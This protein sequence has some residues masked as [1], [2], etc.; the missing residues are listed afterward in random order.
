MFSENFVEL[1]GIL[2]ANDYLL[3]V[4]MGQTKTSNSLEGSRSDH[5]YVQ[6]YQ[7]CRESV[8]FLVKAS[9]IFLPCPAVQ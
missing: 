8:L 9:A 4:G 2:V 5:F 3:N 7:K 1:I 6:G